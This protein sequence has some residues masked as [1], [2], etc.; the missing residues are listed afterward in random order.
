[1]RVAAIPTTPCQISKSDSDSDSDSGQA[2]AASE[3]STAFWLKRTQSSA[4][5]KQQKMQTAK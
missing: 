2:V 4:E 1:M 5:K 3:M